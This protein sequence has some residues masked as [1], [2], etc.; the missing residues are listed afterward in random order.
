MSYYQLSQ[1]IP[2]KLREVLGGELAQAVKI[3]G[4]PKQ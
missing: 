2:L 3:D 4:R 1:G